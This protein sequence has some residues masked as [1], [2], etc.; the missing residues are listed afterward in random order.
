MPS[1]PELDALVTAA[2]AGDD[3]AM[4]VLHA[5]FSPLIRRL[6]RRN[7]WLRARDLDEDLLDEAHVRFPE[8]VKGYDPAR[9]VPFEGY[10]RPALERALLSA[11]QQLTRPYA[12]EAEMDDA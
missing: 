2:R 10:I 11:A 1:D 3:A 5:R 12:H 7:A 9:G 4:A 6:A 8:L